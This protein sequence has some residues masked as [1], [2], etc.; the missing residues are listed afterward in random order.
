MS[1][2]N[3]SLS[4]SMSFLRRF[5][6]Y[7]GERFPGHIALLYSVLF[8]LCVLVFTDTS[9]TG[10]DFVSAPFII[11][12]AT[13]FLFFVRLRL[14]DEIKDYRYDSQYHSERPVTR[15][16]LRLTEIKYLILIT[17]VLEFIFQ[18]GNTYAGIITYGIFLLYSYFMYKEFYRKSFFSQHLLAGL[19]AHQFIFMLA[20]L[21]AL[22]T[23]QQR[24]PELD[25][26]FFI[27]ILFMFAPPF[28]FELGR[29]LEHRK[30]DR[31]ENTDDTYIF[32]WG[33]VSSFL[34]LMIISFIQG[35][36]LTYLLGDR[37]YFG[38]AYNGVLVL[39]IIWFLKSRFVV[40]KTAKYWSVLLAL[41]G[42]ALYVVNK[43]GI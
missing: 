34:F 32:R 24:L 27:F 36:A 22:S 14:V 29:K 35:T 33:L 38:L 41:L 30:D 21:F 13:I 6:T 43:I 31:G 11:V 7:I 37:Y 28:M 1:D 3:T 8:S 20:T 15:G 9:V 4:H 5:A 26:N 10:G 42:M 16:I 19:L 39:T 25:P 12:T 18:L 23:M 40:S 2:T 17:L